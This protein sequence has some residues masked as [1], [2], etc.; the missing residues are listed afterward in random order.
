MTE[1]RHT[2]A[3]Y[4]EGDI[5]K[6]RELTERVPRLSAQQIGEI[7]VTLPGWS[8]YKWPQPQGRNLK[9]FVVGICKR[10]NIPFTDT[11]TRPKAASQPRRMVGRSGDST[12]PPLPSQLGESATKQ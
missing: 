12:L 2:N 9:G 10:N 1:T 3:K 4:T 6:I 8:R 11:T 7:L 5:A